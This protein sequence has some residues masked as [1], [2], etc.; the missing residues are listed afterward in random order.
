MMESTYCLYKLTCTMNG[1]G[2]VGFTNNFARRMRE[3][4]KTAADGQGQAIHAAIRKYGWDSFVSEELYYSTDKQHTLDMEDRF[5]DLYETKGA[6]GYNITRGGQSGPPKGYKRRPMTEEQLTALRERAVDPAIR[7]KISEGLKGNTNG[8]GGKGKV[9]SF[10]SRLKMT[11]SNRGKGGSDRQK[12]IVRSLMQGNQHA[13]GH[14]HT[15][16][17]KRGASEFMK[18][19]AADHR[20]QRS[21]AQRKSWL[22]RKAVSA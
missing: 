4:K 3:H 13:A 5:I 12:A 20:Q 9:R 6:K 22:K 19:Y 16:E 1:K 14:K 17:W 15:G 8:K 18:Q 11:I 7:Q 10:E 2:Y 21:E